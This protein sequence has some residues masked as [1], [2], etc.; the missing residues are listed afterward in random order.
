MFS[1]TGQDDRRFSTVGGE[2]MSPFS[3]PHWD[4]LKSTLASD[5]GRQSSA[6]RRR[7][8]RRGWININ[9][10]LN[11]LEKW[12][13]KS[14]RTTKSKICVHLFSDRHSFTG[15]W[16][17]LGLSSSDSSS[18][19]SVQRFYFIHSSAHCVRHQYLALKSAKRR[20]FRFRHQFDQ[21]RLNFSNSNL[22]IFETNCCLSKWV[23]SYYY[24]RLLT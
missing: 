15:C 14:R 3:R 6:R 16:E 1:L 5:R 12:N 8:R 13:S 10:A 21:S 18:N 20:N 17:R 24:K 11:S 7:R 19:L 4:E 22:M 9:D 23:R 2:F